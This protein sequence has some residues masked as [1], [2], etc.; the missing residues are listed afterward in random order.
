MFYGQEI[1]NDSVYNVTTTINLE[2]QKADLTAKKEVEDRLKSKKK[3]LKEA[4]KAEKK[5]KQFQKEQKQFENKHNS[6]NKNRN[7]ILY[8]LNVLKF[9]YSNKTYQ[10]VDTD[11][12]SFIQIFINLSLT[13]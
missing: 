5:Q 11:Y 9:T 2:Q 12:S 7:Q 1:K 3:A 8:E 4:E 10:N 6:R 13:L